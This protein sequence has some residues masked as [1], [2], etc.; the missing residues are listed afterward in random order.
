MKKILAM[1]M[2]I[3]MMM[4]VAVPAFAAIDKDTTKEDD[5]SQLGKVTVATITDDTDATYTVTY[6]ANFTFEWD[7]VA[8]QDANYSVTSQLPIGDKLT[9][10]VAADNGGKMTST[11]AAA[12][13]LTY[14]LAG[15]IAAKDFSEINNGEGPDE[16]ITIGIAQ[17]Q[18]DQAVPA[19]YQGTVTYKVVYTAA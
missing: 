7:D 5:G 9:V 3:V 6:P 4:A 12:Y 11:T 13:S 16:A 17:A 18:Y 1:A 2:A 19:V 8:T 10:S 14:T 15:G